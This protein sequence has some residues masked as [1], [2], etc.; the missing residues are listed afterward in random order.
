M[1]GYITLWKWFLIVLWIFCWGMFVTHSSLLRLTLHSSLGNIKHPHT[2][3]IRFH[4][5]CIIH[6]VNQIMVNI[7]W[8]FGLN[9]RTNNNTFSRPWNSFLF[10]FN[11]YTLKSLLS[12]RLPSIFLYL[13]FCLFLFSTLFHAMFVM[14]LSPSC[15]LSFF[16]FSAAWIFFLH[17]FF[18]NPL[19]PEFFLILAH[20][21]YKMWIIHE[22]K[23]VAL[24]NKRHFEEEKTESM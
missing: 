7:P 17:H 11:I 20:P 24:W 9:T 15:F 19:E 10:Y 13:F 2:L 12:S 1:S 23:K 14:C 8:Y 18:L 6:I 5:A 21:V 16:S 4:N 3:L 22:P